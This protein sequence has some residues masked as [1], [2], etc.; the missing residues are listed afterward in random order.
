MRSIQTAPP[1]GLPVSIGEVKDRGRIRESD[2]D[3]AIDRY[4]RMAV[5]LAQA[6]TQRQ[7]LTA[8]WTTYHDTFPSWS[9]TG[10]AI[11]LGWGPL[12]SVLLVRYIDGA[13]VEQ[14][15]PTTDYVVDAIALVP[16]VLPAPGKF[17][18][19]TQFERRNAVYVSYTAGY[20]NLPNQ[21]PEPIR[22][23]IISRVLT[24]Y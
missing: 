16:A 5:E 7:L 13:G 2:S 4:I 6:Y 15:V 18:P 3:G 14:T 22:A 24:A 11:K 20:G 12:Q 17:W 21:V 19:L 8:T 10:C 9:S 1:V 23:W